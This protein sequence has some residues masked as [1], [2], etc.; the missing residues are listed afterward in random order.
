MLKNLLMALFVVMQGAAFA[1]IAVIVHPSQGAAISQ[2]DISRVFMGRSGDIAGETFIPV[3]LADSH[4]AKAHFDQAVL[5]RSSSQIKAYWSR[6]VFTGKG[7]PPKE[8]GSDSEVLTLVAKN[9][10][11]IGYV[12]LSMVDDSVRVVATF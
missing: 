12:P 3:N 10:N 4:P 11:I 1:E 5:G 8:V 6:L 7:T 2:D 9:P